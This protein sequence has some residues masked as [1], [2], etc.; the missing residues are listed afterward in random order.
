MHRYCHESAQYF[1]DDNFYKEVEIIKSGMVEKI[2]MQWGTCEKA[3]KKCRDFS[4]MNLICEMTS[5]LGDSLT[6]IDCK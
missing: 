2:A 1:V 3:F 4:N 6:R 5:Y